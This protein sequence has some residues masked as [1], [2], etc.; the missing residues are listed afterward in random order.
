M[1]AHARTLL[2]QAQ[3]TIVRRTRTGH[4]Q[5]KI[6]LQVAWSAVTLLPPGQHPAES[7]SQPILGWCVRCWNCAEDLE[8]I[9]FTTLPLSQYDALEQISWYEHRWLIEEYHKCLKT[10]CAIEKRQ[11]ETTK[12]LL[13]MLGFLSVT[14]VRLLQLRGLARTRPEQ[15]ALEAGI[16]PLFLQLVAARLKREATQLTVGQFWRGVAMIGGFIGRRSDGEPGWQT[17]WDGWR[18]LQDMCFGAQW[19]MKRV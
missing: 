1:K 19:A 13:A 12:G 2:P 15:L 3:K 9:L 10:G 18:R 8:W 16:E 17:L 11:M 4:E 7:K 5:R 6:V 14:A